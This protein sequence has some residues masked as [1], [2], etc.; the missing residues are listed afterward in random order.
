MDP[1]VDDLAAPPR[2]LM[3]GGRASMCPF[4]TRWQPGRAHRSAPM[5]GMTACGALTVGSK[6]APRRASSTTFAAGRCRRVGWARARNKPAGGDAL[7]FARLQS[8]NSAVQADITRPGRRRPTAHGREDVE[9]LLEADPFVMACHAVGRAAVDVGGIPALRHHRASVRASVAIGTGLMPRTCSA[10][11]WIRCSIS[12]SGRTSWRGFPRRSIPRPSSPA[13]SHAGWRGCSRYLGLAEA[14]RNADVGFDPAFARDHVELQ[15]P[16]TTP[17]FSVTRPSRS[18]APAPM[19]R[20]SA[21]RTIRVGEIGGDL[22]RGS[23]L[24]FVTL[25]ALHRGRARPAA[26]L[27]HVHIGAVGCASSR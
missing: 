3:V 7:P 4:S 6:P 13:G 27:A 5:F 10:W 1:A 15:P 20:S 9:E 21:A 12:P 17:M 19:L 24:G 14:E 8:F 22:R 11:R 23:R 26:A 18:A 16:L 25:R 2:P